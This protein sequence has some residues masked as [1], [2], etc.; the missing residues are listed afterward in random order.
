MNGFK[1]SCGCNTVC[2]LRKFQRLPR[3]E[4]VVICQGIWVS[5]RLL[6]LLSGW[7][8]VEILFMRWRGWRWS[9]KTLRSHGNMLGT[10]CPFSS[11]E[12]PLFFFAGQHLCLMMAARPKC[13]CQWSR[14]KR[15]PESFSQSYHLKVWMHLQEIPMCT[16]I[17]MR[18]PASV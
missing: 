6:Y 12:T 11:A 5:G 10:C 17:W 2:D 14:V 4:S 16:K 1:E 18:Y 13:F 8:K 9:A 3:S 7:D 15:W